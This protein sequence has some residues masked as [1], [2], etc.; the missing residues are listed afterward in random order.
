MSKWKVNL[1]RVVTATVEVEATHAQQAIEK[2]LE[3]GTTEGISVE[4]TSNSLDVVD[5]S[6]LTS[7]QGD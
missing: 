5:V 1:R 3:A 6:Q 2:G 7:S 4:V